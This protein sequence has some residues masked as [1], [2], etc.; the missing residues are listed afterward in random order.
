M[1]AHWLELQNGGSHREIARGS[2]MV[3]LHLLKKDVPAAYHFDCR[4]VRDT[5]VEGTI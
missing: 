4:A 2:T 5:I 1:L 3:R